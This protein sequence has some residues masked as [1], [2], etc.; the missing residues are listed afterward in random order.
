MLV[1]INDLLDVTQIESGKLVL[2]KVSIE[3]QNF[4]AESVSRHAA[5]A[6]PKGTRVLLDDCPAGTV[7]AD[8]RRLRQ[9]MDNLISNGVK[10]SPPGSAVR[11]SAQSTPLEWRVA[12]QDQGPGIT[13][14]D[15]RRLFQDFARLS[16]QPTGGE[17]STGLGLA[18]TRRVVQAHSG[19][20]GVDSEPG[21]GA[22]FW[23]TLPISS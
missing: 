13:E 20:I 14:K 5:L 7:M 2:N 21:R 11:V 18:I 1:L 4:L 9:V 12:V 23:F 22:S 3:L 17:K 6:T 19:Q 15:R 10:Y 8:P 16:A